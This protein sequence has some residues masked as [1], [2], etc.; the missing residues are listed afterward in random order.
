MAITNLYTMSDHE[1]LTE[2]ALRIKK[3]RL[4][5]N[6]TRDDVASFSGKSKNTVKNLENGIGT[7]AS[8]IPILRALRALDQLNNLIPDPPVSPILLMKQKAPRLRARKS[9]KRIHLISG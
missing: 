4:R 1:I 3:L 2:V 5:H 8:L 9:T 7:L 6:L